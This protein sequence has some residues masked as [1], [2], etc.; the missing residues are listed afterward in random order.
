MVDSIQPVLTT[1][2]V[3]LF[4]STLAVLCYNYA[5]YPILVFLA[6]KLFPAADRQSVTSSQEHLPR[7]TV[8]IAAYNAEHHIK[9]RIRNVL[10]CDYPHDRIEVLGA[11]AGSTDATVSLVETMDHPHVRAVA[12]SERRGKTRTLVDAVQQVDS[13]VILFTD[14]TNQFEQ[15]SIRHLVRHFADPHTGIVTG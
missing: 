2:L 3:F 10:A 6:A 7:V 1:S 8:R 12:F 14:A 4:W 5:G 9:E 11:S 15:D 13:D